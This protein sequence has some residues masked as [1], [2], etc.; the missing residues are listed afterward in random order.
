MRVHRLTRD[1]P[2][3]GRSAMNN[4]QSKG[5][6]FLWPVLF[7][8][9]FINGFEAGGYQAS[10]W[11]IGRVFDLSMTSMGLY[12]AMELL[13]TMLAPLLLGRW[14]DS[15]RKSTSI[16]LLLG[17]QI[18]ASLTALFSRSDM[19]FL[20][21]IFFLGLTTS[22]LQ[23]I[24]IA[25]LADA[26]PVS[27][28]RRIA[29]MTTMYATG[30]LVSPLVVDYY[31]RHGIS[32]RALFGML[33]LGSALCLAGIRAAG[34]EPREARPGTASRSG[35]GR[36]IL[37]GVLLLGVIMCIYV[38]F[39]NGFTFFVDTLFTDVL[40]ASTGKYALSLFW[41][42]MI[43]SRFLVGRFSAHAR[44]ILVGAILVIPACMG[45]IAMTVSPSAVMLLC[46]P[47]GFASGAIYPCALTLL[48]PFAGKKTATATGI[49]TSATGI[50]GFAFTAMTGFLADRFGM[51]SAMLIL[52]S[53]FG[54]SLV[55][56]IAA[57]R[58]SR[59]V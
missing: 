32:W 31:L 9:V 53:F 3:K 54:F 28:G 2:R 1:G 12:A 6:D 50:G 36:L 27:G 41:A 20:V 22:A 59:D 14:A 10:L 7:L 38:G 40:K 58:Q 44:K 51:R 30:A 55:C 13:A 21:S 48:M 4:S 37:S 15:V 35:E 25:A 43:P 24:S 8:I 5:R 17:L 16:S 11:S 26:Y 45:L 18:A 52:V 49:I 33:S 46:V 47:L 23:F 57:I 39:E 19:W 56:A 42:T 29:Y 34:S